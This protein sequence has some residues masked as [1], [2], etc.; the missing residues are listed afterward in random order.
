MQTPNFFLVGAPK[1]GT[2]SLFHYLG[3]HPEIAVA[4]VKE[5]CFFAPEVP[6]DPATD[7]YRR[8][9]KTYLTLFAHAR[10]EHAIGEGS[11]AYLGSPSAAAAIRSRIP[12][13][14][15]PITAK[16]QAMASS[17]AFGWPS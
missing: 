13:A 16:L 15:V 7:A 4:T 17:K 3:R 9:W 6:V 1:A 2:T 14:R 5:P 11:V 8:S 10:G 12:G